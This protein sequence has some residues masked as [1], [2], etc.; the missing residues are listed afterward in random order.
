M[1]SKRRFVTVL[2]LPPTETATWRVRLPVPVLAA[3]FGA[4]TLLTLWAGVMTARQADYW[5]MKADNKMMRVKV[6]FLSDEIGKSRDAVER[7]SEADRQ[8]RAL[9]QLPTRRAIVESAASTSSL[10]AANLG[11]Q[12]GPSAADRVD[13]LMKLRQL[14]AA[15]DPDAVRVR[16]ALV[17]QESD[18]ALSSFQEL[19]DMLARERALLRATPIGWPAPGRVTSQY[20]YRVSPVDEE[21]GAEF[22]PGLD[23]AN[24]KG[25][26]IIATADGV[27]KQ[28]GWVRG[29]GRVV[30]IDHGRGF[31]TLYG[32]ASELLVRRGQ[33]VRRGDTIARMG[34]TGRST[35]SHVH[36]EVWVRGRTVNPR[37]Y[38]KEPELRASNDAKTT[39]AAR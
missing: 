27:V 14:P 23:I 16:A 10:V 15:Q 1:A 18:R 11:P 24:A 3:A 26:P 25:T 21:D 2:V 20:G 33:A 5:A 12:G 13:L 7:A 8:L 9:L 32:H 34:S 30:V 28:A 39:A 4:W 37:K 22:H 35:G 17:R 36:Y 31:S 19:L 6:A 29:Y 38:L